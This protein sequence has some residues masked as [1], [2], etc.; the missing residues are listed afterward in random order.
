MGKI[1]TRV[2]GDEEIEKKEKKLQKEKAKKK[3][4][5][6]GKDLP[7]NLSGQ[8]SVIP[9]SD[10][11]SSNQADALDPR[12][13]GD[14]NG[15]T[16]DDGGAV[17]KKPK[18]ET[19]ARKRGKNYLLAKSQVKQKLSG[20]LQKKGINLKQAIE[21]LKKIKYA[22]FD[23]SIEIHIKILE[24][25]L[26]GEVKLP[27]SIGKEVRV[28]V[29]DDKTIEQ[30]EK[31][32]I[33]FDIL[34][35]HPSYMPKIVKFAKILGPKGLM[36][37]PKAGT[38]SEKPEETA[39]KFESGILKWKSEAKQPLIH[40]QIA[41]ISYDQKKIEENINMFVKSVGKSKILEMFIVSTMSPSIRVDV[42]SL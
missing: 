20:E 27:N 36:P 25:G 17:K 2:I 38:I 39:K 7:I 32:K 37:N 12:F 16:R 9:D 5:V 11:E 3:K 22:K 35:A 42:S 41:K 4:Q 18:K 10:R 26:R 13:H 14:D 34:I 24:E 19:I 33:D 40:Q 30:I 6:K 23:E 15:G 21:L 31:G 1:R 29:I 8:S 28:R